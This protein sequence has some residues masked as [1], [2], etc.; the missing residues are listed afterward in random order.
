MEYKPL[1]AYGIFKIIYSPFKA[2]KEIIQNP[3]YIGPVL[4][5]VLF[6]LASIGSEYARASKL[7]V[8]QTLPNMLDPYNPGPWTE[9]C[10]MWVSNAEITCNTD[11]F[12]LGRKSI[13]FNI[14]NNDTI[15]ME[16]KNIDQINCLSTDGY[17]NLSFCIKWINPT[18]DPPQNAS[19]YLFSMGTTDHFYYDLAERINQTENYKWNNFTIPVG[20]DAEKWANSSAQTAW[21]NITGLKLNLVWAQSTGS[22]LTILVDKVYFQS[23]NFEPLINSMGSILVF[24]AFNAVTTFSI[25]WMLSGMAVFIVGKLFRIKA[26]FKVSLI[27]VGYA[28][29]AMVVMQVLFNILYLLI[30]PLYITIDAISPTSVLQTIILFN[31]SMVLLLPVWSILISSIG[32]HTASDLPLS[33]SAV[34]AIIGF[35]PYYVLLFIA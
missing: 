30:S 15:Q 7:Y 12:L 24:A 8:Q 31:S 25:Y 2:F 27:I 29:I 26:G 17:K 18:A 3:K 6:V 13:Q 19:L 14:I 20:L 5:M 35:L 23:A 1:F 33:K 32:V 4:I 34:I 28:L 21:N 22:N 9:N 10:T 16:L 11:D